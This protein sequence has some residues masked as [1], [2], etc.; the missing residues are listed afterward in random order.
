MAALLGRNNN[1]N[2]GIAFL[3]TATLG[4]HRNKNK[5]EIP[6]RKVFRDTE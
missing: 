4:I 5:R 3:L 1:V 6:P 2:W